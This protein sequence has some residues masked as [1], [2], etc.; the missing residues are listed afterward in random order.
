MYSFKRFKISINLFNCPNIVFFVFPPPFI[1]VF[2]RPIS[3]PRFQI[4]VFIHILS[5]T[6]DILFISSPIIH[7]SWLTMSVYSSLLPLSLPSPSHSHVKFHVVPCVPNRLLLSIVVL[8]KF[9][10]LRS[11]PTFVFFQFPLFSRSYSFS[12]QMHK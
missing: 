4:H 5:W 10:L 7:I 3:I 9:I 8:H 2:T 1:A 6:E 12:F 11:L